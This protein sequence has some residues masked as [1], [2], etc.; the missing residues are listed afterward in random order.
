M[1]LPSHG[2]DP[3]FESQRAHAWGILPPRDLPMKFVL[4]YFLFYQV[5]FERKTLYKRFKKGDI[6]RNE[7]N[8][9]LKKAGL[10]LFLTTVDI[11]EQEVYEFYKSRDMVEEHFDTFKNDLQADKTY[12]RSNE[13]PFGHI[14]TSFLSLFVYKKIVNRLNRANLIAHY[15]PHDVLTR[16]SGIYKCK[17]GGRDELT[18]IPKKVHTLAKDLNYHIFPK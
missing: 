1:T 12:L 11:S 5:N 16:F 18:E 10:V 9:R 6:S 14:F 8:E 15:S 7:L 2:R 17:V 4:G 13:A 3:E